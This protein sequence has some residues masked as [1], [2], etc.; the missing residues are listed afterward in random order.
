MGFHA[1]GCCDLPGRSGRTGWAFRRGVGTT[2]ELRSTVDGDTGSGMLTGIL[3]H[4]HHV[5]PYSAAH[6]QSDRAADVSPDPTRTPGAAALSSAQDYS[7]VLAAHGSRDPASIGEVEA[8]LQLM[9]RLAPDRMI[10]HGFLEFAVP[11]LD[12]GGKAVIDAGAGR[13]VML[14]AVLRAATHA[15]NDMPGEPALHKRRFP[16]VEVHF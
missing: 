7:I 6:G 13:V 2:D 3:R 10:G 1:E 5:D 14:P 15:K 9:R 16:N 12:E 4:E 11:T 8:L